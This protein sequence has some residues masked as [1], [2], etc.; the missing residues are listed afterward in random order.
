MKA[1]IHNFASFFYIAWS[2][3][4]EQ[5]GMLS[6]IFVVYLNGWTIILE[7]NF[8]EEFG[9]C[10]TEG[11]RVLLRG[12]KSQWYIQSKL[13]PS[14]NLTHACFWC[15]GFRD[16]LHFIFII[17]AHC[18][19]HYMQTF[20]KFI[21]LQLLNLVKLII[22]FCTT[23]KISIFIFCIYV[24]KSNRNRMALLCKGDHCKQDAH[25]ESVIACRQ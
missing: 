20:G 18:L 4:L 24:S 5:S 13:N 2:N 8:L 23:G 21:N 12:H 11:L 22:T 6:F 7:K 25:P 14:A 19:A 17:F 15:S 9:T 3:R 1:P 10:R 16:I